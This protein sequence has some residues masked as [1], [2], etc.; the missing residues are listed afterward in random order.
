MAPF[1][2]SKAQIKGQVEEAQGKRSND[3]LELAVHSA[4]GDGS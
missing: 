3:E 2:F 4:Y 1:T